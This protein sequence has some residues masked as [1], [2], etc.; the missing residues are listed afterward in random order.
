MML[1][2]ENK[3]NKICQKKIIVS[4]KF[5][6]WIN[7]YMRWEHSEKARYYEA[8]IKKD[9]LGDIVLIKTWGSKYSRLGNNTQEIY[10][11]YEEALKKL[12]NLHQYRIKRGYHFVQSV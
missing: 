8:Y 5:Y 4:Y 1:E 3:Y 6:K 9:L 2:Y 12:L 11:S 7:I 10:I